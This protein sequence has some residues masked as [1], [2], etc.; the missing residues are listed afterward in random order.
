VTEIEVVRDPAQAAL[1]MQPGRLR[2][3]EELSEPDSASGVAR[4]LELPRQQVNYHLRELEKSGL[5][6]F[7]EERRK[8]N[9]LE[10]RVRASA[11]SYLISP[12]TLGQ[13][14]KDTAR[15]RDRFSVGYLLQAASRII[16]ELAILLPRAEQAGKRLATLTLETEVRFGSPE[17]RSAFTDELAATV[18]KIAAKYNTGK[19]EGRLFR[20]M[21]GAYPAITKDK[22]EPS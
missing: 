12:D 2:V 16:R 17:E 21:L 7:V 3:L 6:K 22:G 5:V 13:L 14:G 9:C 15:D 18:L 4:R 10:R 8:G 19:A 11:R 1:L 20:I